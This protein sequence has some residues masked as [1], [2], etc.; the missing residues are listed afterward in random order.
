MI[1]KTEQNNKE[2]DESTLNSKGLWTNQIGD[3]VDIYALA[4]EVVCMDYITVTKQQGRRRP[5]KV[6]VYE[7]LPPVEVETL[8]KAREHIC[9]EISGWPFEVFL[10]GKALDGTKKQCD[11]LEEYCKDVMCSRLKWAWEEAQELEAEEVME[12]AQEV[13]AP[14]MTT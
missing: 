14:A 5:F 9:E 4:E 3:T 1:M 13:G 10:E 6:D 2:V 12:E 7:W 11:Q 8:E